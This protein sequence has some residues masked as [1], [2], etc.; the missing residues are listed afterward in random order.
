M[1]T[2]TEHLTTLATNPPAPPVT[3]GPAAG[4][5]PTPVRLAQG[6]HGLSGKIKTF[7]S[8]AVCL[9]QKEDPQMDT[10]EPWDERWC[11]LRG[12]GVPRNEEQDRPPFP[13]ELPQSPVPEPS[14]PE[15]IWLGDGNISLRQS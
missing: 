1:G 9:S 15:A 14:L 8:T 7:I 13:C 3:H 11:L 2:R 10:L 5:H 6:N 12:R 4:P